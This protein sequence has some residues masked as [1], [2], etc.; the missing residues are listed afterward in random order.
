MKKSLERVLFM[1]VG[2]ILVLLGGVFWPQDKQVNAQN[3]NEQVFGTIICRELKVVDALGEV[4]AGIGS[5][6]KGGFVTVVGKDKIGRLTPVIMLTEN[7][8]GGSVLILGKDKKSAAGLSIQEHLPGRFGGIVTVKND[9]SPRNALKGTAY[10]YA[11]EYGGGLAI[12][13]NAGKNVGMFGATDIGSC[14]LLTKDK[15]GNMI[16]SVP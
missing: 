8:H 7:E 11:A 16:G 6:A 2:S 10:I 5:D 1:C 3:T 14:H 4:R 15:D 13:N 9:E 12:Y